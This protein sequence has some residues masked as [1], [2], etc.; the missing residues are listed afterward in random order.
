MRGFSATFP[1]RCGTRPFAS[2]PRVNPV[3]NEHFTC[4]KPRTMP[5]PAVQK[6]YSTLIEQSME[7][8]RIKT[9]G[10]DGIWHLSEASWFVDQDKGTIVFTSPK[11]L[12]ATASVQVIGTYNSEDGTWLWGWDNPSVDAALQT[13]A[14]K[15]KAF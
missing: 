6:D 10:H 11:G 7:E 4:R 3:E 15:V 2:A 9:T 13:D 1:K 5:T 14:K 8:L 12:T